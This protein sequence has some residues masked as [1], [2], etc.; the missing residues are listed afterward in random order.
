MMDSHNMYTTMSIASIGP[1]TVE[2]PV[3]RSLPGLGHSIYNILQYSNISSYL[4][5]HGFI[6]R[7][8]NDVSDIDGAIFTSKFEKYVNK[9]QHNAAEIPGSYP[10]QLIRPLDA[11]ERN[12][13]DFTLAVDDIE[14]T[15]F[16]IRDRMLSTKRHVDPL[17]PEYNLPSFTI[18]VPMEPRFIR[19]TMTTIGKLQLRA[20]MVHVFN[21]A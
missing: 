3:K 14:G 10:K 15:R 1:A 6:G 20:S 11:A 19:D 7:K 4:H 2:Q 5:V 9:P 17:K 8:T 12:R 16:S 13:P 18:A 21:C